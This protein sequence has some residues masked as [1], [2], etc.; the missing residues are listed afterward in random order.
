MRSDGGCVSNGPQRGDSVNWC[1]MVEG[2]K[3]HLALPEASTWR[4]LDVGF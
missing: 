2:A 3:K 4:R 1:R